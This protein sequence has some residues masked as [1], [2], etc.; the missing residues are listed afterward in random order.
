[1][2]DCTRR[3]LFGSLAALAA[4]AP[5]QAKA[6]NWK[7]RLGVLINYSESN[8]EWMR[9]QGFTSV[10]LGAGKQFGPDLP[11]AEI[12]KAKAAIERSGLLVSSLMASENHTV[13]D[14][15]ARKA[16]NARFVKLIEFAGRLGVTQI[17]TM[18]GNMPGKKLEE[19][20]A[21]V[22][23]VYTELYFPACEKHKVR[24]LWEPWRDGP[25]IAVGPAGY[26]ALFKGFG[27]SPYVG[28]CYDP[29][30][31]Q[32]QFMDP[33]QCARDF[34]DKIYDVHL[35]DVEIMWHVVRKHGIRP[36]NNARWWRFRLP[37]FGSVDWAAFFTVLQDAGFQGAMNIEHE[38][39]FYYP[40]YDGAN[41][42]DSFK[43]GIRACHDYLRQYVPS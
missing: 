21:E 40:A 24:L 20:A 25:N 1:M 34:A 38:D 4:S 3:T 32:A 35:K 2:N 26:E 31:L 33:I 15:D 42:S 13:P 22:V 7:P 8:L 41:F 39:A 5:I 14:P 29:S 28:L 23:R 11:E 19:Q 43:A 10:Q 36:I 12:E 30:H 6:R 27:D 18:S 37:G 16:V 9:Q 17:A